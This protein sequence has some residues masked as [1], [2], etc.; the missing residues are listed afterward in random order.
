[1]KIAHKIT[2]FDHI[3]AYFVNEAKV[4]ILS[5]LWFK[6]KTVPVRS[7]CVCVSVCERER[8]TEREHTHA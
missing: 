5:I 8:E 6:K 3:N 2:R 7:V 1:M 4:A